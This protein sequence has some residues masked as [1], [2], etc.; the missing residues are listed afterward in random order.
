MDRSRGLVCP[1]IKLA[2]KGI[3]AIPRVSI[4]APVFEFLSGLIAGCGLMSVH[5]FAGMMFGNM[6]EGWELTFDLKSRV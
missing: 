6:L 2:I 1:F 4:S 3:K 5:G